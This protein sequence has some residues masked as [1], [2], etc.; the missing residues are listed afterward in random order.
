MSGSTI[1]AAYVASRPVASAV[2]SKRPRTA[3]MVFASAVSPVAPLIGVAAPMT[4]PGV[5]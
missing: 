4:A 5:I 3:E 1:A 2:D